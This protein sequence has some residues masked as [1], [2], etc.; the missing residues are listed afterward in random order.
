VPGRYGVAVA[1]EPRLPSGASLAFSY[2]IH[3]LAPDELP[4]TPYPTPARYADWLAVL[5]VQE[6]GTY[7][8]V[9]TTRPATDFV[10]AALERPGEYLLGAPVTPP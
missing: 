9:A 3:F 4:T 5:R 8:F 7:R 10:R 6:D 1:A 2:A